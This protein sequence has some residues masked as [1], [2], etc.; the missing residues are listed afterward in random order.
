MGRDPRVIGGGAWGAL[1]WRA[2][3]ASGFAL[4]RLPATHAPA[5]SAARFPGAKYIRQVGPHAWF[6]WGRRGGGVGE[7]QR[8][9]LDLGAVWMGRWVPGVDEV[10][11]E[12]VADHVVEPLGP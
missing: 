8:M 10:L 11:L 6:V 1:T 5:G 7:A 12:E 2:A 3:Y 4:K 9:P